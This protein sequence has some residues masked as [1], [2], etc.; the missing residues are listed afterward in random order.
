MRRFFILAATLSVCTAAA[1]AQT[2]ISGTIQCQKPDPNYLI[3][4]GDSPS[5]SLAL[6]QAKC[7]WTK[8]LEIGGDKSKEGT[9]TSTGE[10]TGNTGKGRGFHVGTM[11]SGDKYFLR[12]QD[13]STANDGVPTGIK[14]TWEFT[15][16]TGKMKG[17]KGTFTCGPFAV[18]TLSCEVEGE[19]QLAK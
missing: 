2:K 17:I 3:P 13:S 7:T 9:N 5:H 15:G 12:Y 8:P 19:Y 18:E 1:S 6:E 4:V 16:G 14:G 10:A 11:E